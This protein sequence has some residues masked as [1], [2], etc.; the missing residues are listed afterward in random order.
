MIVGTIVY[1]G[2]Y[3]PDLLPHICKKVSDSGI[4]INC[5]VSLLWPLSNPWQFAPKTRPKP[6]ILKPQPQN[7][8]PQPQI[9]NPNL[10]RRICLG[11][12]VW[13][14][15]LSMLSEFPNFIIKS[16]YKGIRRPI[17]QTMCRPI[18]LKYE[19]VWCTCAQGFNHYLGCDYR[20]DWDCVDQC[21][22]FVD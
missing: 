9:N 17:S 10:Q 3:H 2:H 22:A 8:K 16:S 4:R 19:L 14:P 20:D 18:G 21:F 11:R 7:P 13:L 5:K 15:P 12:I 6:K 1:G